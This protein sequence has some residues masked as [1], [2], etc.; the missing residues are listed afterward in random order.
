MKKINIQLFGQDFPP[1][2]GIEEI[3]EKV[4]KIADID[5]KIN[6]LFILREE[7]VKDFKEAIEKENN[8]KV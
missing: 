6:E 1:Y 3:K 4:D 2:Y 8:R 7:Y 5:L